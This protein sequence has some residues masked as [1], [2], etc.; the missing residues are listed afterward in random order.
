MTLKSF[1]FSPKLLIICSS[2][3][4][5]NA[6]SG[7]Y[8]ARAEY[9]FAIPGVEYVIANNLCKIYINITG[10]MIKWYN[11]DKEAEQFNKIDSIYYY[12]VTG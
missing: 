6:A 7:A 8:N 2:S 10:N 12:C 5:L 4:M 9:F 1:D 11:T 3:I